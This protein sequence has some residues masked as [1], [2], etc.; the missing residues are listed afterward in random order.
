MINWLENWAE[1]IIIS[2]IIGTII[3]MIIPEGN[4]KKYVRTIIGVYIMF[5][6]ISPVITKFTS[7]EVLFS[8]NDYETYYKKT[9]TYEELNESFEKSNE[10]K[11]EEIYIDKLNEDIKDKLKQKGYLVNNIEL[12][13]NTKNNEEYGMITKMNINLDLLSDEKK[14]EENIDDSK[15]IKKVVVNKISINNDKNYD[16]NE[17]KEIPNANELKSYLSEEYGI[18]TNNIKINNK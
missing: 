15:E 18:A 5:S 11:I 12:E 3:E 8:L 7:K 6:I 14:K 2:V 17:V 1:G 4:N 9:N 13:I 16:K 10:I